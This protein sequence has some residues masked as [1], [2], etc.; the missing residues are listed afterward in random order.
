MGI[1]SI[2]R[3]YEQGSLNRDQLTDTPHALFEQWFA[4]AIQSAD[5]PDPTAMVLATA[6]A[7]GRPAQRVVLLKGSSPEG[8]CFYTNYNSRK[9]QDLDENPQC[10]LHF[11]WLGMERQIIIEG[12]A[13]RLTDAENDAYFASRPRQSQLGAWASAQSETV[14]SREAL[15]QKFADATTQFATEAHIPRPEFWGGYRIQPLRY[16][17]WQGGRAR[18]HDRFIYERARSGQGQ[19]LWSISR[20]QP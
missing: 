10:C 3:D 8:Y 12:T 4:A 9:A 13:E 14:A 17:F 18:L 19:H 20:L 16:E 11:A 1:D 2:R 7:T 5:T 15:D 6:S